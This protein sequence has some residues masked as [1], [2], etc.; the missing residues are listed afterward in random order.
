MAQQP[1]TIVNGAGALLRRAAR[2]CLA[3]KGWWRGAGIALVVAA[4][5]AAAVAAIDL[6]R[7]ASPTLPGRNVATEGGFLGR[8]RRPSAHHYVSSR[9]NRCVAGHGHSESR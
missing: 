8:H 1:E 5:T 3:L 2:A 4:L 9:R 7:Q 6:A